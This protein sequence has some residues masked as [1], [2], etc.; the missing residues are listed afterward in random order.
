MGK[1]TV[2][3][4]KV[5]CSSMYEYDPAVL[6]CMERLKAQP[7]VKKVAIKG[8]GRDGLRKPWDQLGHRYVIIHVYK[9]N[10]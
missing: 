8:C 4:H 2:E 7:D 5:Y 6:Q 3:K 1:W 9:L 10:Q